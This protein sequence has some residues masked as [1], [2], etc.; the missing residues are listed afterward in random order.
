MSQ[1]PIGLAGGNPND[2]AY[3]RNTNLWVDFLGLAEMYHLVAS[4]SGTYRVEEWGVQNPTKT[5]KLKKGEICKIGE[6]KN[7]K[8][9]YSQSWLAS[10]NLSYKKVTNGWNPKSRMRVRER[11]AID[12][13]V[14]R[15]GKLPPGNKCRH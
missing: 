2:F 3:V 6:T 14:K 4:K 13:Y 5:V 12:K 1:D 9:R 8:T 15:W 7:P 10:N 11:N